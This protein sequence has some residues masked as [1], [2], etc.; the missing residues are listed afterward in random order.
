MD[1]GVVM[2]KFNAY[3]IKKKRHSQESLFCQWVQRARREWRRALYELL[4]H[5]GFG[6]QHKEHIR[7]RIVV[8]IQVRELQLIPNLRVEMMVQEACQLEEV[9][10][11]I[12]QQGEEACTIQK[13]VQGLTK[14]TRWRKQNYERDRG[15]KGNTAAEHVVDVATR[16]T[17]GTE[18][19][20][21]PGGSPA[22]MTC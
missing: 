4:E 8:G 6:A 20:L 22:Y 12:S 17:R 19:V 10:A 16:S 15:S 14:N 11:Q 5:C 18:N 7:E 21:Q 1:Y 9:K 2:L 13:V 3:I